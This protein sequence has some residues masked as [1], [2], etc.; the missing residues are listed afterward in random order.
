MDVLPFALNALRARITR[1]FPAQIRTAV[2][3]LTEEQIWWRPNESSNS[4]GNLVLHLT[5][6]LN[7]YLNRNL[8]R[9]DFTR[10]RAAEFA[11]RGPRDARGRSLRDLDLQT[12]LVKY[13]LSYLIYSESFDALPMPIKNYVYTRLREV[14]GGRDQSPEFAHL[15]TD[16]RTAILEILQDTKPEAVAGSQSSVVSSQ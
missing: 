15:S 12:R 14:L 4:I 11:A 3:A 8:G 6:S 16:D 7:Y 9:I 1:V 13:P 5:G 10:D 2:N